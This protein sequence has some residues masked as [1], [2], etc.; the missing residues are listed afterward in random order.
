MNHKLFFS[1]DHNG[2]ALLKELITYSKGRGF[3]TEEFPVGHLDYIDV[4]LKAVEF[5][6]QNPEG[7]SILVCASGLGVCMAANRD[8]NIRA[9]LCRIPEDARLARRQN[10]AN[11]LCLGSRYTSTFVAKQCLDQFLGEPFKK[12]NHQRSV[13]KLNS[14]F[15]S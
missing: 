9:A 7:R 5:I 3:E 4:T 12:E 8:P 1:S 15:V 2:I 13:D 11:I 10:D 14:F 6:H